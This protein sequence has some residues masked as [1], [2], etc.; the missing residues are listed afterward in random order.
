MNTESQST[1]VEK[2][3]F[4]HLPKTTHKDAII[5]LFSQSIIYTYLSDAVSFDL[6]N[7]MD[8]PTSIAL[9]LMGYNSYQDND[10]FESNVT[11][12]VNHYSRFKSL[13]QDHIKIKKRGKKIYE[14]V[15]IEIEKLNKN[16]KHYG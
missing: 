10:R 11:N 3:D 13:P 8:D 1:E 15:K 14:A 4:I 9:E 7:F 2:K 12:I 5:H 6:I 16:P